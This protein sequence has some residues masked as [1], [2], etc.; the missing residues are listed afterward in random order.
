MHRLALALHRPVSELA[1]DLDEFIDW[2]AFEQI[3]PFPDQRAEFMLAEFMAVF[4]NSFSKK[5]V[6]VD[7]FLL[8]EL[9]AKGRRARQTATDEQIVSIFKALA[10]GKR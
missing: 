5:K 7:D 4:V 10:N 9:I 3:H 1:I 2:M 6:G 8:S